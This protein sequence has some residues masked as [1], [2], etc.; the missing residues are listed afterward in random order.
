LPLTTERKVKIRA[1][2][3][4]K[5]VKKDEFIRALSAWVFAGEEARV[6]KELPKW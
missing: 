5:E 1:I 4:Y 6:I 3:E 2:Y